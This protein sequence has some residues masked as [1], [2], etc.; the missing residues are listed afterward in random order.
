MKQIFIIIGWLLSGFVYGQET[1]TTDFLTEITKHDI[2][3]LWTLKKFR[4]E[5]ENDTSWI[6]R[7][8]PLG[9]IRE[10]YQ[11]FYIHFSSVIQ[12]PNNGLEYFV[13]GKTRVKTNICSFQGLIKIK[14]AKTYND[15]EIPSIKQGFVRGNYEFYED[16]DQK[17]TGILKGKFRTDF[18]VDKNG[19]IKYNS[20]MF[21]ADGFENNQFEGTWTSYK[22]YDSKIPDSKDLDC[23]ASEFGV[24]EKYV[25]NG[26]LT[27]M[28]AN[29]IG[30][31]LNGEM[32]KAENEKWWI[33]K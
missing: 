5:F 29:G 30:T 19:Q 33:D 1:K 10:N 28:V 31:D 7:M 8:E 21:I 11:R 4:T 23:G 22:S 14:E 9:Y 27:Y 2:S 6:E 20:L 13:Y 18:Y 16:S 3:D 32:K 15:N 26:W 17:G 24:S 25:S 12:N